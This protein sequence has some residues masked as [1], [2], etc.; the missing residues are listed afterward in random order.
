LYFIAFG[1]SEETTWMWQITNFVEI[2]YGFEIGLHFFT[3]YKDPETFQ[4]VTSLKSIAINYIIRGS[5][6]KDVI[7]FFP[8]ALVFP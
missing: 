6:F 3:T 5:F 1:F 4:T 2:L 8:F 7:A